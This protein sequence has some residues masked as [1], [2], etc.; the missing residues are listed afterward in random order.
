MTRNTL[1]F[2]LERLRFLINI[3]KCYLEPTSTLEFLGV[4]VNS[5]EIPLSLPEEKVL[6]V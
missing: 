6:K 3:K 2:I 1:T 4:I 5:A